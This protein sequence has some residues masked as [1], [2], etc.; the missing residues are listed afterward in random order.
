MLFLGN[1]PQS[2]WLPRDF[3]VF[4][5]FSIMATAELCPLIR[6]SQAVSYFAPFCPFLSWLP[7]ALPTQ[8]AGF[9]QW[10]GPMFSSGCAAPQWGMGYNHS[11][12]SPRYSLDDVSL[13]GEFH[14]SLW[15]PAHF[16]I[17][18]MRGVHAHCGDGHCEVTRHLALQALP[19]RSPIYMGDVTYLL[20]CCSPESD[21]LW[22]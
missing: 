22:G 6:L 9:L 10:P 14:P 3:W 21:P 15:L 19:G 12:P 18:N 20:C 11:W 16:R 4:L 2:S 8:V 13:E 1:C 5:P 17:L 7:R